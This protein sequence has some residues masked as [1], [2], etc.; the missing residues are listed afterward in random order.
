MHMRIWDSPLD[1]PKFCEA[2]RK[3]DPSLSES[4]LRVLAKMLKNKENKVDVPTLITNL[5]GKD[6]ET[7]DYRNKIFK[8]VYQS[9]YPHNEK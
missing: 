2:L 9:I 3:L 5:S 4:Q 8:R 7:V 1:Y 6:F